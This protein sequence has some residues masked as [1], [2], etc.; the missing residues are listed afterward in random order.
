MT[1]ELKE[2]IERHRFWSPAEGRLHFLVLAL[3]GEAGEL[4][5]LMKKNWRGAP[6]NW[7]DV[8]KELA[9]IGAYAFMIASE[10]GVDLETEILRKVKEVEQRPSWKA[11]VRTLDAA[12]ARALETALENSTSHAPP[13]ATYTHG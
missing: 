8:V 9:D 11:H 1:P 2:I 13:A 5:N 4:A 10:L 7:S 6:T 12:H 3:C